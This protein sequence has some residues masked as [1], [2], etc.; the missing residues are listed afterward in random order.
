MAAPPATYRQPMATS[1]TLTWTITMSLRSAG[2]S[3]RGGSYSTRAIVSS[4]STT[5]IT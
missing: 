3:A 1:I 2:T 4:T 5:G